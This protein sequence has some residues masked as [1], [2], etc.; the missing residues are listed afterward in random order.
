MRVN[1]LN[2][3]FGTILFSEKRDV[4][5]YIRTASDFLG[6]LNII[7]DLN[8]NIVI[9]IIDLLSEFGKLD[10]F[11]FERFFRKIESDPPSFKILTLNFIGF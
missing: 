1:R 4:D 5:S 7:D 2:W 8:C 3:F 9:T 10:A 6:G 11:D